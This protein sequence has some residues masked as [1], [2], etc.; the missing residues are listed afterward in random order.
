LL[1]TRDGKTLISK[2][3]HGSVAVWSFPSGK[4][5]HQLPGRYEKDPAVAVSPDGKTVATGLDKVISFWDLATGKE[6]RRFESPVGDTQGLAFSPDG[7]VLASI[8]GG[9]LVHLWDLDTGKALAKLPVEHNY[10]CLLA[11]TP[12]GKTLATSGTLDKTIR[13][14]D[15]ASR[16]ERLKLERPSSL[17]DFAL[18]A[19]GAMLAAGGDDGTIPLWDVGTGKLLRE[20]QGP[21]QTVDAVAWSPDGKLLA[22]G[23]YEGKSGVG[24][25]RLWD[26]AT[27]KELRHIEGSWWA[28]S[29]LFTADGMTLISGDG[30]GI[31]R[32]WDV[33]TLEDRSP[34]AG[35]DSVISCL[36][37]SPDGKT[38]AYD[39]HRGI[40]IWDVATRREVG[41]L[42]GYAS[43]FAF[44]SDSKMLAGGAAGGDNNAIRL[45][46]VARRTPVRTLSI[47]LKKLDLKWFNIYRVA[48]APD[49]K[50]LASCGEGPSPKAKSVRLEFVHLWDPATGS[51]LRRLEFQDNADDFVTV[52]AVDFSPDGQT[53]IASAWAETKAGRVRVW[54]VA[55]GKVLTEVTTAI[56]SWFPTWERGKLQSPRVPPR[57]VF[58]PDGRLLALNCAEKSIPVWEAVTGRER[59]RLEGH[60]GATACVV[61]APDGR[62]LASAGYDQTIRLWDVETGKELR[63]LTGHRG[64]PN[65]LAFTPDGKTLI[66]GGYDT[67]VLFWDVAGITRR[68]RPTTRISPQEAEALWNDLAE[69][70][71]VKAHQAIARLAASPGTVAVLKERLRPA[72]K[73]DADRLERLLRDLGS[74][75]FAVR[76]QATRD[77]EK[78]GETARPAIERALAHED[79]SLE[80]RRRLER[81]QT[82]LAVPSGERLRELRALEALERLA[83]PEARQLVQELATGA[84]DA[85]LT[86]EAKAALARLAAR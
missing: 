82:Q 54:D 27:G 28:E 80:V 83:T 86:R 45:W 56:N 70:N 13:L 46:D 26:T 64:K 17:H 36:A 12:D 30:S 62:T 5:L 32:L 58:S 69:A 34:A 38:L 65:A 63:K 11:F 40:G 67:T 25:I 59:C 41:T 23:D 3:Y 6:L 8:S 7:K 35:N 4:L 18:S 61:F 75:D 55:T 74:E 1:L 66:S 44:T 51:E 84:A 47:D 39:H 33:A 71:A 31:I 77:L 2:A 85:R 79:A 16:K 49:G 68:A 81:L 60:D 76:A 37:L 24:S 53:L 21:G 9:S 42:P 57:V 19:D 78:L 73:P 20:L 50:T 22:T 10:S 72:A 43:S 15:V 52:E 29:L 48:F 14:F